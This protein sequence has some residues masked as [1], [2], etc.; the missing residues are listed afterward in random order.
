MPVPVIVV[1]AAAGRAQR[2]HRPRHGRR[3]VRH[4]KRMLQAA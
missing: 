2:L 1:A 4:A 3:L